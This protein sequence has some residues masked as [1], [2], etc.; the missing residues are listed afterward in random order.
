M[1]AP[2][3]GSVSNTSSE[4]GAPAESLVTR[5]D[6]VRALADETE[7][8]L[9]TVEVTIRVRVP[10]LVPDTQVER[11]VLNALGDRMPL[12]GWE[13]GPVEVRG[14]G[15][16]DGEEG[17]QPDSDSDSDVEVGCGCECPWRNSQADGREICGG[18]GGAWWRG[19]RRGVTDVLPGL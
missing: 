1:S 3:G 10:V 16:A 4:D 19:E 2:G 11:V 14:N 12:L 15:F 5:T 8:G 9:R 17:A 13:T 7:A 18:C 6:R